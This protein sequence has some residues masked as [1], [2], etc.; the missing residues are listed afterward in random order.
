MIKLSGRA[1][2]VWLITIYFEGPPAAQNRIGP[3]VH[4]R[5]YMVL[6]VGTAEDCWIVALCQQSQPLK[7]ITE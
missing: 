1:A 7:C 5:P 2:R 4:V 3:S 6:M